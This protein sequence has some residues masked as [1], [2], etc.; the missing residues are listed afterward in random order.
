MNNDEYIKLEEKTK[1]GDF[2][3]PFVRYYS[4]IPDHFKDFPIHWHEEMEIIMAK[5]GKANYYID[6]ET[7]GIEEG[8]IIILRPS[9]LHSL[10]QKD[11]IRYESESMLFNL[12]IVNNN[13]IDLCSA[14]YFTPIINNQVKI[15]FIIKRTD[16]GYS[17]IKNIL[18][19]IFNCYNAK[20]NGYELL[21]KANILKFFYYLFKNSRIQ[22]NNSIETKNYMVEK[23]KEI[24]N[25]IEKN[26]SEMI[27]IK[28][29]S[30]L[31]NM[32]EYHLM[33]S[34]KK[35][36]GMTCIE[37]IN[38]YRLKI[39]SKLLKTTDL[40]IINIS[41]E[42]GFNNI[43]YFNKLFKERFNVTPKEYRRSS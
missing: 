15:P 8:D 11:D 1:H 6:L 43:S 35:C 29:L 34:F 13:S 20:E 10:R 27:S 28:D 21:L 2:L 38:N 16:E 31:A 36:T 32:S 40:S 33:R 12:N 23:I 4:I 22:K 9:V 30:V 19:E 41:I 24:L 3:M 14:K 37:Y 5:K 26:Y 42:S 25:Y 7:Y 17:D 18:I 39:A